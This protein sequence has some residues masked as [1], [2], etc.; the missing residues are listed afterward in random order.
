MGL[1]LL[2]STFALLKMHDQLPVYAVYFCAELICCLVL[3]DILL[4]WY[5]NVLHLC[6]VY[7]SLFGWHYYCFFYWEYFVV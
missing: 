2:P 3:L 1:R 4:Y 6:S 5:Y 7:I